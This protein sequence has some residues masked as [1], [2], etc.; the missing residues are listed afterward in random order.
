MEPLVSASQR[1]G[2]RFVARLCNEWA[3]G[4]NRFDRPGEALYG[5]LGDAGLAGVGGLNRQDES[6][7][8]LRHFYILP[9]YRRRGMGRSLLTHVLSRAAAHFRWVVL[10]TDTVSADKFYRA[11]GFARVQ[12]SGSATHR[13]G[14]PANN[15]N[16]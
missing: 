5:V 2:F 15:T 7:G 9:P 13:I 14:L 3:D 6:T 12:D 8:R 16:G 10:R 11:C 1:E 4:T